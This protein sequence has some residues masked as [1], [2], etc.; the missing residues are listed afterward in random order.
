[1]PAETSRLTATE[2]IA[3]F[4]SEQ[5]TVEAYTQSLLDRVEKRDST[6]KAWAYIDRAQVLERARYLDNV[7]KAQRGP[8]HG[9]AVGIKDVIYTKSKL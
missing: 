1:M 7:P 6:V 3:A 2:A 8:L 9:V 4:Q 5:L